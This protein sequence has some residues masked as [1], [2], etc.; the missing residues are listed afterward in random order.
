MHILSFRWRKQLD[1]HRWRRG[2]Q[3]GGESLLTLREQF[4]WIWPILP[5]NRVVIG[6]YACR[7]VAKK[8]ACC[9]QWIARVGGGSQR[10]AA[11]S[12]LR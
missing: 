5:R 12:G 4:R 11:R 2:D 6:P 10:N 3:P 7:A 8:I 9:R 1:G